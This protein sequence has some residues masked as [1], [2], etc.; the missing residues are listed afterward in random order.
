LGAENGMKNL[1]NLE[2]IENDFRLQQYRNLE[3]WD[4]IFKIL[5]KRYKKLQFFLQDMAELLW[6]INSATGVQLD[7]IGHISG[8]PR[9]LGMSDLIY[10]QF[11]R[12]NNLKNSFGTF[13]EIVQFL[14][15]HTADS[16]P[17][18][19]QEHPFG[20]LVCFTPNGVEADTAKLN[21]FSA[22]GVLP[23][24][25]NYF[26]MADDENDVLQFIDNSIW[27]L[28]KENVQN[29][30]IIFQITFIFVGGNPSS[31]VISINNYKGKKNQKEFILYNLHDGISWKFTSNDPNFQ[32]TGSTFEIYDGIFNY[33]IEINLEP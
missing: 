2:K 16:E 1:P 31:F 15:M 8:V 12:D 29:T 22:A 32:N 25:G 27:L 26:Q 7:N 5:L 10:R 14:I 30:E 23:L 9:L 21:N 24:V 17:E 4:K 13:P 19:I 33:E 20:S 3:N 6:C 11:I 18:I 28:A